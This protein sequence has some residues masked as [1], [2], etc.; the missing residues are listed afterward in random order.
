MIEACEWEVVMKTYSTCQAS[1][2][3]MAG[4]LNQC[5]LCVNSKA[6]QERRALFYASMQ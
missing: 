1:S 3:S 2:E 4:T 5:V 6:L